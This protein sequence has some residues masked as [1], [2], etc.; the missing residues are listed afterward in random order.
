VNA[1]DRF[2]LAP[3]AADPDGV[4][5]IDGPSGTSVTRA[6]LAA[7]VLEAATALAELGVQAEQR[8]LLVMADRPAFLFAFFGAMAI[9][10]V[11]VP[12]S[13]MLT[14][15]DYRFLVEDSRAVALIVSDVFADE[16]LPAT[17]DQRFLR[18]VLFD[19]ANHHDHPETSFLARCANA[20]P[21][22]L[23]EVFPAADDDTAFWLYTSGTTGFPK[24]AVH[25][26]VD[27]GFLT[28][29]YASGVLAMGP[30]DRVYS[31]PKLF[32]AYGLGNAYFAL[33]TRAALVL[34]PG[35]PTV[36]SVA[37]QVARHRV[38]LF[39]AV[40]TF[41][42][43]TL[44]ADMEPGVF[45]TVRQGITGGEPLP[46]DIGRRFLERFGV[47]LLDGI[48]TTEVG[49]IFISQRPGRVRPGATGWPVAGFEIELRGDDGSLVPEGEPGNLHVAGE[50]VTTGYWR[51][52]DLNRRVFSGR[53]LATGDTFVRNGD[54]S[55]SYLGRNDDMIKAGGIWVSP[56]EVEACILE[57]DEIELAAV[58]GSKDADGLTKPK[59]FVVPTAAGARLSPSQLE[60]RVQTHVKTRLAPFKYPRWVEVRYE[61]PMT[62]TGKIKRYLLRSDAGSQG[63]G[64]AT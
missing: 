1:I 34:N 18:H 48:G 40:P 61:L 26:Q 5:V 49:H 11:P 50:S 36:D 27:L 31:V 25:R 16:V 41:L 2:V 57:L 32:F 24:A 42:A 43:Q 13:T 22:A 6:N 17:T 51:R 7:G 46:P 38:T 58:V 23:G 29:A 15:K 28:D 14:A 4:A 54:G 35:P 30:T 63:G 56:S 8:V 44:A 62:A 53:F 3:A 19:P 64:G 47:E 10:A 9:G 21:L 39:F 59:A 33:G 55:Y 60:A 12:V 37:E 20:D 52:T 45:A